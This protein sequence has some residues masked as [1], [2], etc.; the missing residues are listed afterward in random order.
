MTLLTTEFCS[1]QS[2]VKRTNLWVPSA[3]FRG[4]QSHEFG[5][6]TINIHAHNKARFAHGGIRWYPWP[7]VHSRNLC[8]GDVIMYYVSILGR[9]VGS[10]NV[11]IEFRIK[12]VVLLFKKTKWNYF[13]FEFRKEYRYSFLNSIH[14]GWQ[15]ILIH[16]HDGS[17]WFKGSKQFVHHWCTLPWTYN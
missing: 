8:Q 12:N 17:Y 5:P 15:N 11:L 10:I 16:F 14:E 9:S 4:K 13:Q 6:G 3:K 2:P 7:A 1:L